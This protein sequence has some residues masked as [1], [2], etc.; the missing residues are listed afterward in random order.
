MFPSRDQSCEAKP[1][2]V[3][4]HV[5]RNHWN[6]LD[7]SLFQE[8]SRLTGV[9]WQRF[10]RFLNHW[11]L[12]AKESETWENYASG[13]HAAWKH[14]WTWEH[15]NIQ[16]FAKICK[17]WESV[18][19]ILNLANLMNP[20][21]HENICGS[22]NYKCKL[23]RWNNH[24]ILWTHPVLDATKAGWQRAVLAVLLEAWLPKP[25]CPISTRGTYTSIIKYLLHHIGL[26]AVRA[27]VR[28][29]LP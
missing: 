5:G 7:I 13:R 6:P 22:D 17:T 9:R 15:P 10:T 20:L 29:S 16:K 14:V 3:G 11:L 2:H 23:S 25:T 21:W 24:L 26:P 28:S 1:T 18:S 27:T 12:L 4:S 8:Y 19:N